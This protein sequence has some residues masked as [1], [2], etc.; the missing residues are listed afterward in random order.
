VFGVLVTALPTVA[1]VVLLSATGLPAWLSM[2]ALLALLAWSLESSAVA[3]LRWIRE[4]TGDPDAALRT[5][6][7]LRSFG[8]AG[9][10]Q[11]VVAQAGDAL[12]AGATTTLVLSLLV[13]AGVLLPLSLGGAKRHAVEARWSQTRSVATGALVGA[14]NFALVLGIARLVNPGASGGSPLAAAFTQTRGWVLAAIV[15]AST[16]VIPLAEESFFRGWLMPAL[17]REVGD[18]RVA[19]VLSAAVFAMV[20]AG[21]AWAPALWAGLL[22]GVL[23]QRSGRLA[24]SLAM[25][26]TNNVLVVVAVLLGR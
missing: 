6:P 18:A 19:V 23:M 9:L 16:T 2:V 21:A 11:V 13:F 26:V 20:H 24:T 25:H 5:W 14:A 22:A 8:A 12:G 4:P 3:R 1:L 17:R 15:V 7:A 10:A